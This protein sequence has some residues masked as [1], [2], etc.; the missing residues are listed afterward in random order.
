MRSLHKMFIFDHGLRRAPPHRPPVRALHCVGH[1]HCVVHRQASWAAQQRWKLS[2]AAPFHFQEILDMEK[3][4]VNY[5]KVRLSVRPSV[6]LCSA[7]LCCAHTRTNAH[8]PRTHTRSHTYRHRQTQ[9]LTQTHRR[10]HTRTHAR[11]HISTYAD[12]AGLSMCF[13]CGSGWA[14]HVLSMKIRL[15][16]PYAFHAESPLSRALFCGSGLY[17]LRSDCLSDCM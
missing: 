1:Y 4:H 6:P 2:T 16:Q 11:R 3:P 10:T 12:Q 13:P 17:A 8:S 14:S 5:R 7:M 15:G 9:T